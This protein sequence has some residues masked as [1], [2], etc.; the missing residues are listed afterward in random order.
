MNILLAP[1]SLP[2]YEF[3][4]ATP[5]LSGYEYFISHTYNNFCKKWFKKMSAASMKA[6]RALSRTSS[7]SLEVADCLKNL[8]SLIHSVRHQ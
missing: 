5:S 3:L 7:A 8:P 2:G 6:V 1:P 4:L